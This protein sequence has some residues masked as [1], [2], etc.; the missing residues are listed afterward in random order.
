MKKTDTNETQAQDVASRASSALPS[1]SRAPRERRLFEAVREG[2][3]EKLPAR[4]LRDVLAKAGLLEGDPRLAESLAA[5]DRVMT[6]PTQTD[7]DFETFAKVVKPDILVIERALRGNLVLPEF[8][9]FCAQL[10]SIYDQVK[11]NQSG[12]VADY[13]PQLGRV[14]PEQFGVSVVS[15]DGQRHS[16]GES[17]VDFCVQSCCKPINYCLALEEHDADH[18]HRH[19]GCEPSGHTFNELTL[20][21]QGRPHNPMINAG[22]IMSCSLIR[23]DLTMA[24]RFDH[25]MKM[26]KRLAGGTKPG[27]SNATYLSERRT[28]DRNFALG[29]FMREKRAFPEKTDLVSTLE[30]YFQCCSIEMTAESMSMVAATL[31]N[32]GVCPV[33]G[34]RILRPDTVRKCLTLMYS[35][36]MYDFSGEWAF[37]IGLPAKSGVSGAVM[38]VVPNVLGLC[39]WSPRL[40]AQGNSVRGIEFCRELVQTYNFHNYD[41][42]GAHDKIDPR[43]QAGE[44]E[45]DLVGDLC[46]AAS[47][48]DLGALRRLVAQGVSLDAADYDGRTPVHLAASEGHAHVVE[49]FADHGVRLDPRDRWGNTPLEDAKREGHDEIVRLLTPS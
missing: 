12:A 34:E 38:V 20:N 49:F 39:I 10:R 41:S 8:E 18:V 43:R 7:L 26:W 37:H 14:D 9:A 17:D 28:A 19:I 3:G 31:A 15:V 47:E 30:F 29:Y 21:S 33:T 42:L 36:G 48:G 24:D 35:C 46:W 5:L 6:T 22:A 13:I 27:F 4:Y 11:P 23:T 2:A 1:G 32:G 40:D 16:I 45:R 25:V 44:A